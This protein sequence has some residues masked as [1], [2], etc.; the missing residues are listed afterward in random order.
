MQALCAR[1]DHIA[2]RTGAAGLDSLAHRVNELT[3][4]L[5]TRVEQVGPLPQNIEALVQ[6]LSDKLNHSDF[7]SRDQAAFEHIERQILHIADKLDAADHKTGDLRAIERGI[8]QLTLQVR[9]ARE[10][11]I[12]TAERVAR[13][14]AADMADAV[15]APGADV[16]A[17]KRD[18]ES[19]HV[20]HVE[21]EQR[22][23]ETL[24][25]VHDTL[26]R[27]VE[28]LA[29]IETGVA[30]RPR[31]RRPMRRRRSPSRRHRRRCRRSMRRRCSPPNRRRCL[32]RARCEPIAP[33]EP[34]PAVPARATP[35]VHVQRTER[36][37]IDP[38]LPA[39]TPLEPG[40]AGRAALARRAHRRLGS[41]TRPAQARAGPEITGKANFIAA[42][43]R[44]AQAAASEGSPVEGPRSEERTRRRDTDQP[45]RPLPRRSPP[46]P[47]GRREPLLVL[48]GAIQVIGMFG[49]DRGAERPAPTVAGTRAAQAAAAA[50]QGR[51][52]GG[53]GS[54]R[55]AGRRRQQPQPRRL[56]PSRPRP[57]R[58]SR[59]F[60]RPP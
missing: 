55:N 38:D 37:P 36:P 4:A 48:Y 7:A 59:P 21:S 34:A 30:R 40:S 35:F 58:W 28:R 41:R 51:G 5:D 50:A 43:R 1:I 47:D 60:R 23:H 2:E 10:E 3:H 29:T 11:A 14:V 45:D 33:R 20:T 52:A 26:E 57:S 19:L 53:T 27:L 17:L 32:R 25:A 9:E 24:E 56:R 46:R 13:K 6:A 42:A 31:R 8:Q 22:T 39:D 49:G 44:A 15:P 18:L 54:A 16:S 12:A